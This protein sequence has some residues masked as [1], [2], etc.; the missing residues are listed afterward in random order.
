MNAHTSV[1][2]SKGVSASEELR[3]DRSLTRPVPRSWPAAKSARMIELHNAGWSYGGISRALKV[4]RSAVASQIKRLKGRKDERLK[5]PLPERDRLAE[6]VANGAESPSAIAD[7]TG[8]SPF[9]QQQ[10]W[11]LICRD[12][13][14][15]AR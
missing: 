14:W 8:L 2:A 13:G 9:R 7:Q 15:Q 5:T 3:P 6:A 12:L 10:L 4:T 11:H 1:E